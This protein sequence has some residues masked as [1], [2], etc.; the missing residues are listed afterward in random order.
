MR[1]PKRQKQQ[2]KL[3]DLIRDL[4]RDLSEGKSQVVALEETYKRLE[5]SERLCQELAG[6]NRRLLAEISAWQERCARGEESERQL[7]ALRRQL[8]TLEAE[9]ARAVER[10]LQLEPGI[11]ASGLTAGAP[12]ARN[13]ALMA[14]IAA[15]AARAK[16]AA[17][18]WV[19]ENRRVA[20]GLAGVLVLVLAAVLALPGS[21]PERPDRPPTPFSE[22]GAGAEPVPEAA[23]KPAAVQSA[24]RVRGVFQ[25]IRPTRVYSEPS[26][27]SDRVADIGKGTRVNVVNGRNGWLEIHSKHGRPPGF[28]RRDA[29]ERVASN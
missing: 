15:Y 10:N 4:E 9:H 7:R 12:S 22:R 16:Q 29:A 20:A 26:E 8:Q 17:Q 6:E 19:G 14:A 2:E 18:S 24:P 28:I 3:E 27:D 5:E 21:K 11:A 1:Q 23:V 25:T 13:S